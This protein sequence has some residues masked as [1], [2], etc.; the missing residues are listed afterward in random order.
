MKPLYLSP[1]FAT[2]LL[3]LSFN[4]N[5][6]GSGIKVRCEEE[7][8][9]A[10][11]TINGVFKG[12][13]PLVIEVEPGRLTFRAFKSD[14]NYDYLFEQDIRMGDGAFKDI[15]VVLEKRLNAAGQRAENAR[16][17]AEIAAAA[18]QEAQRQEALR[19]QAIAL[20]AEH[21]AYIAKGPEMIAIPGK[22]YEM[23]KY[24]VTQAEWRAIMGSNPSDIH[25]EPRTVTNCVVDKNPV[26]SVSWNDVQEFLQKL[27][28]QTG[29]QYRL[30]TET[31]W[32]YACAGGQNSISDFF[33]RPG[34]N[35]LY[36]G[37]E[38]LDAL[39]WYDGNSGGKSHPVGQKQANGYGLYDMSGNVWEWMANEYNGG[40]ALRGGSWNYISDLARA[41]YRSS[42]SPEDRIYNRGFRLSRT[43]P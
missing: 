17:A 25:C 7:N 2:L 29:K 11:I 35:P 24:E 42:L 14:S 18:R 10:E 3:F 5:A 13:C 32:E 8:V 31:E 1:L 15:Y 20:I 23:G 41:A 26:D 28:A 40:R 19:Q 33:S 16:L 37:G 34:G 39:G 4:A 36:C 12:E 38:N 22:N 9:G 6:K 27:N 43:L 21:D 30:P